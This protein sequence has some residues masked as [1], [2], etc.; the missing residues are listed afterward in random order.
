MAHPAPLTFLLANEQAEEIKLATISMRRFY[1][2][3]RVEAVYS[4]EEALEYA[5]KQDWHVI[6]M[7]EQLS[8]RKGFEIL[9]ELKARAPAA[10]IMLQTETYDTPMVLQ[11]LQIGADYCVWKKSPA[12]LTELPLA[13]KQVLDKRDLHL[14]LLKIEQALASLATEVAQ[15]L[16]EILRGTEALLKQSH[17]QPTTDQLQK[18]ARQAA[19][20]AE[21]AK[22]LSTVTQRTGSEASAGVTAGPAQETG[23][24]SPGG[25]IVSPIPEPRQTV[26]PSLS[27]KPP[28]PTAERRK[29]PRI[30]LLAEAC[31]KLNHATC[32]GIALNIS[33]TGLYMIFNDRVPASEHQPI[34]I[35][36][37]S[38]PAIL[39]IPGQIR[40]IRRTAGREEA[41]E[42]THRT[43]LAIEFQIS[44]SPEGLV[45]ASLIDELRERSISITVTASLSP[46]G[47]QDLRF[48]AESAAL[49]AE[50]TP[51]E[52]ARWKPDSAQDSASLSSPSDYWRLLNHIHHLIGNLKD[53]E[54][55]LD[56]GCGNGSLGAFLL[57][58]QAYRLRITSGEHLPRTHYVGIDSPSNTLAHARL[59]LD[60]LAAD[61]QGYVLAAGVS[62]HLLN[63]SFCS[64]DLNHA[65]PFRDAQFNR[66]VCNLVIGYLQEPLGFLH[67][68]IRVL[69]PKGML[70][71]TSLNPQADVPIQFAGR[72]P[73]TWEPD[74]PGN[75]E[76]LWGNLV[77]LQQ[78][79]RQGMPRSPNKQELTALVTSCGANQPLIYSAFADQ[80]YIVVAGK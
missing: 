61:L 47:S 35:G 80:A 45:L 16:N 3:C 78:P 6:L 21:S 17:S 39:E 40:E 33:L 12:F 19:Q 74:D 41:S 44:S 69:A 43:G 38:G 55:M 66:I 58:E 1:P 64:A 32:Q 2:G 46:E 14:R 5:S 57:I 11:A 77:Q 31:L 28:A 36:L 7:D 4:V 54:W 50:W 52:Q 8:G 22:L 18:I 13:M 29:A 30:D 25:A 68:L 56:A 72:G 20:A 34:Q 73:S 65:L 49:S 60:R 63:T 23:Q 24:P 9:P 67:E 70:V 42:L 48:Q 51:T 26:A 15:P 75:A 37:V 10:A 27:D 71:L 53:D 59:I 62:Q 76:S 79:E